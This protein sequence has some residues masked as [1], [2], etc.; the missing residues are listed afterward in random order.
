MNQNVARQPKLLPMAVPSGTPRIL[1]ML[2][3]AMMRDT[4]LVCRPLGASRLAT[5]IATPKNS[6]CPAAT[7]SLAASSIQYCADSA[8]S[9]LPATNTA[10]TRSSSSR[11]SILPVT[12]ASSGPA[13][14]TPMA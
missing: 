7:S 3:P 1:A 8:Q 9:M 2:M 10:M 14:A 4:A 13:I 12:S 6:P 5:T 11:R